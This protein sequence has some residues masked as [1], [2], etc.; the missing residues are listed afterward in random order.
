GCAGGYGGGMMASESFVAPGLRWPAAARL[1]NEPRD[2]GGRLPIA[3]LSGIP[4]FFSYFPWAALEPVSRHPVI[5][6]THPA[7]VFEQVG[8]RTEVERDAHG[9]HRLDAEPGPARAFQV[10]RVAARAVGHVEAGVHRDQQA[11][12]PRSLAVR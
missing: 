12:R 2:A 11:V 8:R 7:A 6:G 10:P 5:A 1:S 4:A 9:A 3:A